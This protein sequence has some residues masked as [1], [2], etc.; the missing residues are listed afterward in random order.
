MARTM[1]Q[2]AYLTAVGRSWR[3]CHEPGGAWGVGGLGGKC[4][5]SEE[6]RPTWKQRKKRRHLYAGLGALV[7]MEVSCIQ[8]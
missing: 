8:V 2:P 5:L 6:K 4:G 1:E 7:T 3:G